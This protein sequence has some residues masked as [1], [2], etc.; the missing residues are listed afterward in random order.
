MEKIDFVLTWVD[1]NDPEWQAEKRK[2]SLG[3]QDDGRVERYRDWDNLQYWFR[4]VEKY[5]SWVNKIY[6][7][8]WGHVPKWL[9]IENDKLIIVNHKDFIPKEY[10]PTF[11]SHPIELNFHRIKGLSEHFIYFNDDMFLINY[12]RDTDF[13]KKGIPC[14]TAALNV[15][16]FDS[17]INTYAHFQAVGII[18]KH[19]K[20]RE[21]IKKKWKLWLNPKN[22]KALFRTLYLLPCPRFPGIYQTHLPSSFLKSTYKEVW[23]LEHSLLDET[24]THKFRNILDY[25]QWVFRNWQLA[26]GTFE[27]RNSNIGKSFIF[28]HDQREEEKVANYITKQKGKMICINDGVITEKEFLQ[29]KQSVI[30]AFEKIL[31]EKSSF[32]K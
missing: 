8:T 28:T 14:D 7:V 20:I 9:N 1:G 23:G 2:Y 26:S 11:S 27:P 13:F 19:F 6:F 12:C 4:G 10:L 17:D 32:E 5:A 21:V 30:N 24:C 16:C 29:Y 22:G 18:N 3:L 25:N 15:H 31:P